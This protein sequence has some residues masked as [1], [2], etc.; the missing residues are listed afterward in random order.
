[1]QDLLF[2]VFSLPSPCFCDDYMR[3]AMLFVRFNSMQCKA[4]NTHTHLEFNGFYI[5]FSINTLQS[6]T[7]YVLRTV[8]SVVVPF[9][10]SFAIGFLHSLSAYLIHCLSVIFIC[11]QLC[12]YSE[13]VYV[14]VCTSPI[15][16][17]PRNANYHHFAS[18]F[19]LLLLLSHSSGSFIKN[20]LEQHTEL[21]DLNCYFY[22]T[23]ILNSVVIISSGQS[24]IGMNERKR[25]LFYQPIN[26]AVYVWMCA[27]AFACPVI[28]KIM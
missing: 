19:L 11:I 28:Y 17:V 27:S 26:C 8:Y 7:F 3:G 24:R 25:I 10:H 12:N 23:A 13:C 18:N 9:H 2:W 15:L 20:I 16:I 4:T 22:L 6:A 5:E 21:R 14:W 1:M